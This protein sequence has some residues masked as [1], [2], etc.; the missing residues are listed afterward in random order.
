MK[1]F[2]KMCGWLMAATALTAAAATDDSP[3]LSA[4]ASPS[5]DDLLPDVVVAKGRGFEIHRS[6]LDAAVLNYTANAKAHGQEVPAVELLERQ[7]LDDLILVK[8]LNGAATAAQKAQAADEAGSNF[9]EVRKQ[10]PTEE[11][12]I[13]QFKASGLTPDQVRSNLVEQATAHIVLVAKANVSDDD[14][15]K[16]YDDNPA[17][18]QEPEKVRVS[19]ITMGGPDA[20]TGAPLANDQME[21]KK[22]QM[23]DLR[24]RA[25]KGEDF[26]KLAEQYSEDAASKQH[27]GEITLVRGMRGLPPEFEAAAFALETN[28]V[29]DVITTQ[30]GF[31]LIKLKERIPAQKAAFADAAPDI[32]RYLETAAVRKMLPEYFAELKKDANVEIDDPKLKDLGDAA[33]AGQSGGVDSIPTDSKPA[34]G[35]H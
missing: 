27:G 33:P 32:R 31:H 10:F 3:S 21:S 18:M 11:L 6:K 28:Q 7:A 23:E 29:S 14:V 16:F 13:R 4:K 1:S 30:F 8:L 35:T 22:K 25:R 26:A 19:F 2:L 15:K 12:M 34:P 9:A 24:D 20:L 5:I 17:Q